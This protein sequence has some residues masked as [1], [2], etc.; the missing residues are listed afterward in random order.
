MTK[1]EN[2]ITAAQKPVQTMTCH[3]DDLC[4]A[5]GFVRKVISRWNPI[6]VLS[7]VRLVAKGGRATVAATDLDFQCEQTFNADG[8]ISV[9]IPPGLVHDLIKMH[10]CAIRIV[11][12]AGADIVTIT[13]GP[14][15]ARLRAMCEVV[16][17]PDFNV[18][19]DEVDRQAEISEADLSRI[20]GSVDHCISTEE[21]RYYLNGV[22]VHSAEGGMC[23][24]ATDGHKLALYRTKLDWSSMPNMIVPSSLVALLRSKM[25]KDGN[26]IIEVSAPTEMRII[27]KSEDWCIKGKVIDGTYPDYTRV[28]PKKNDGTDISLTH[29]ALQMIPG[30]GSGISTAIKLD[31][32]HGQMTVN[33][34]D[35]GEVS[36][37]LQGRGHSVGFNLGYL[38]LFARRASTIR[39]MGQDKGAPH[40]VL[41]EDP[42]LTQVLMPMRVL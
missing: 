9:M 22:Y 38:R 40:L 4:K 3:S 7:Y 19:S 39:I 15:T 20:F 24:V 28:I 1:Q 35:I 33:Q 2:N 13:A 5:I 16:D 10:H 34:P 6:P 11:Y 14:V 27:F 41:T 21:T 12:D 31:P 26:G 32:E 18:T 25:R 23:A 30:F 36:M 8:D 37:P 29:A 17:F 42:D